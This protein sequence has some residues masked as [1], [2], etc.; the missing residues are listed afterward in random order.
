MTTQH[1][2]D[3]AAGPAPSPAPGYPPDV[4]A[5]LAPEGRLRVFRMITGFY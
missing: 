5:D 4:E 3:T 1:I 2:P